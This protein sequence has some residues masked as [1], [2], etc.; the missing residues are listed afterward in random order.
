MAVADE[1]EQDAV[2][3]DAIVPHH[4][5]HGNLAGAGALVDY[6]LNEIRVASHILRR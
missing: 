1:A 6:E 5:F 4:L 3:V 2:A